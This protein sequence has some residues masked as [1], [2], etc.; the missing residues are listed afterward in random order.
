MTPTPELFL[1]SAKSTLD[2]LNQL[3]ATGLAGFE[4]LVSLNLATAKTALSDTAEQLQAG[5]GAKAPQDLAA[6]ATLVQPLAD[7]A[8]AYGRAV[9]G[10][11]TDAGAALTKSAETHMAQVQAQAMAGVDA[12]LKYAPAGSESAVAAIKGALTA[13]Q[14]A[15]QTAQTQAKAAASAVEKNLAAVTEAA[16]QAAKAATKA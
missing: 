7:K 15:L 5:L 8:A 14:Q 13:S 10:I 11:V 3:A 6:A 2:E 4:K 9:A 1:N 12:T 16:T